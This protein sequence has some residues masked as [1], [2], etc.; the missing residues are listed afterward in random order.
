[1]S[2]VHFNA[3]KVPMYG[4]VDVFLIFVS[5]GKVVVSAIEVRAHLD[6]FL[7]ICD[8]KIDLFN[9]IISDSK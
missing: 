3:F 4:R 2:W 6:A 1:M 8:S 5:N 7:V 9:F